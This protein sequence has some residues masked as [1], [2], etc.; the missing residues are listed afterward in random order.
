MVGC[1]STA[2]V[3]DF[4]T[5]PTGRWCGSSDSTLPDDVLNQR[6]SSSVR[7]AWC[8]EVE[9]VDTQ[10]FHRSRQDELNQ[11]YRDRERQGSEQGDRDRTQ[12]REQ[13]GGQGHDGET[14]RGGQ[15]GV[16]NDRR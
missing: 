5:T 10:T 1:R 2:S 14:R 12:G 13:H 4:L 15:S 11:S 3:G 7:G 8:P 6:T 9:R 16:G